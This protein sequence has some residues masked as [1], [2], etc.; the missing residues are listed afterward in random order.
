MN[1]YKVSV[2][3]FNIN[4]KKDKALSPDEKI[5]NHDVVLLQEHLLPS[6]CVN[7]LRQSSQHAVFTTNARRTQGGPFGGVA[8]IIER[9]LPSYLSPSCYQSS[10]HY[11]AIWLADE[12]LINTYLPHDRRSVSFFSS[13]ANPCKKLKTLIS[14]IERLRYK[15]ELIGDLNSDI[16]VSSE[17]KEAFFQC[18]PSAF[19]VLTKDISFTNIHCSGSVSNLDHFIRYHSLETSAVHVNEDERDYDHL[20]LYFDITVTSDIYSSLPSLSHKWF[21]KRDCCSA[22]VPLYLATLGVL[23]STVRFPFHLLCKDAYPT[24][25]NARADLNRYYRDIILS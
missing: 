6:C 24:I 4:G 15:R 17:R 7:F 14:D 13:Y 3:S 5:D 19:E 11:L 21:E 9:S 8:C 23:L 2:C 1:E 10:E 12:I 25:D 20:P 18:L 22:N 16:T